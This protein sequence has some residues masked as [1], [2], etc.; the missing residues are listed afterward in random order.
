M[1]NHSRRLLIAIFF[2]L[3]AQLVA[4]KE[5]EPQIKWQKGPTT[6]RLAGIAEIRIPEGVMFTDK[7][8]A[9]KLLEL[10]HNLPNGDE[11]GALV[12]QHEGEEWYVIFE[13]QELGYI[14]D[15]EREQLD[16]EKLLASMKQ[17]TEEANEERKKKGWPAFH[18]TGWERA[19][20]YD[21]QTHNLTWAIRGRGDSGSS[22]VNHSVRLLGRKGVMSAELVVAPSEY[23]QSVSTFDSLLTGFSFREGSRYAD[24]R[25][26][27]K[28][29]A[30]G[31]TALILGGAGVA[32]TK[33]GFFAKSWK[34]LLA[35]LIA[36]KKLL[37]L[38]FVAIAGLLK[39]LWNFFTNKRSEETTGPQGTA[40]ESEPLSKKEYERVPPAD[41]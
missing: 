7:A 31:L 11:V 16:S 19:P 6:A 32:A 15:D 1:S 18:V 8:G 3:C 23:A 40:T 39:K 21:T 34:V 14:K 29:A 12:S 27:D 24:F 37:I 10:T 4:Q 5:P 2:F 25:Q 36:L 35:V 17:G 22:A 13:F 30:Y 28:I 41:E 26:G 38:V 20:F 33:L 9:Q